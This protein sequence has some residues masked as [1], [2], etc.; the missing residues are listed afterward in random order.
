MESTAVQLLSGSTEE[1]SVIPHFAYL[2]IYLFLCLFFLFFSAAS[3]RSLPCSVGSTHPV[4]TGSISA[5]ALI[6]FPYQ[7]L[8]AKDALPKELEVIF[9]TCIQFPPC[10]F[11]VCFYNSFICMFSKMT[12]VP[13]ILHYNPDRTSMVRRPLMRKTIYNSL[14]KLIMTCQA[15]RGLELINLF[16][17]HLQKKVLSAAS[18]KDAFDR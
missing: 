15:L 17:K 11:Y 1:I 5:F 3:S 13:P 4:F 7:V 10:F 18:S 9:V 14:G 8:L 2:L 6:F 16:L 12:M